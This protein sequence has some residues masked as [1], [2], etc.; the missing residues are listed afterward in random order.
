[1]KKYSAV[2]IGLIMVMLF[3]GCTNGFGFNEKS[4]FEN[5]SE[6]LKEKVEYKEDLGRFDNL[7]LEVDLTVSGV[8]ISASDGDELIYRQIANRKDL[9]ADMKISEKG[10]TITLSFENKPDKK[11]NVGTQNSQTEILIPKNLLTDLEVDLNVGDLSIKSNQ[12]DFEKI[13]SKLDVGA[14]DITITGDQTQLSEIKLSGNVGD[15]KLEMSGDFPKLHTLQT[16]TDV[17]SNSVTL[18]GDYGE[19]LSIKGESHVGELTYELIGNFDQ[20]VDAVLTSN[21]G[22]LNLKL[23]KTSPVELTAE[24]NKFTSKVDINFDD[25]TI[26]ND[27]YLFNTSGKGGTLSIK[28]S[29]NIGDLN[30]KR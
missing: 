18:N 2:A 9:L 5:A 7:V 12:L 8:K 19:K 24:T 6:D 25:Y 29:V 22:E 23:P 20:K 14:M 13:I 30:V 10:K 16:L 17:G 11:I 26:K 4:V 21:T 15:L 3:T 27:A 28:A 1:M